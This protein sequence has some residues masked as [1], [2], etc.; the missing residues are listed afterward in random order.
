MVEQTLLMTSF[1]NCA[2]IYIYAVWRFKFKNY[3]GIVVCAL[4]AISAAQ[5]ITLYTNVD[6]IL[7]FAM[8]FCDCAHN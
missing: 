6:C 8:L 5:K 3:A 2:C 4:S 7:E 1:Y